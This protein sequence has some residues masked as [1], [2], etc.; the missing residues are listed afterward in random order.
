MIMKKI[1]NQFPVYISL[2]D[3][4][5]YKLESASTYT[6][7]MLKRDGKTWDAWCTRTINGWDMI[8][9]MQTDDQFKE[10]DAS[11]YQEMKQKYLSFQKELIAV[12]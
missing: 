1:F 3:E 6:M 9:K 8:K 5:Y 4:A 7:V 10:I 2:S 11:R 12:G